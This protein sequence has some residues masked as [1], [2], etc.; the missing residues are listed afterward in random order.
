MTKPKENHELAARA[1]AKVKSTDLPEGGNLA[2][3]R[4]AYGPS[5]KEARPTHDGNLAAGL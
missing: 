1:G 2:S 3:S 4:W 5:A